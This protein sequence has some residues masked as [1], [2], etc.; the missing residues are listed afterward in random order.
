[1]CGVGN[2]KYKKRM[3]GYPPVFGW[4]IKCFMFDWSMALNSV[5]PLTISHPVSNYGADWGVSRGQKG[6]RCYNYV[7]MSANQIYVNLDARLF[8]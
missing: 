8:P 2:K 5:H 6:G 7:D 4:D 3:E 1:M